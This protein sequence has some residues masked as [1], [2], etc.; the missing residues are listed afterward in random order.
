E[1][2]GRLARAD[3]LD[4]ALDTVDDVERLLPHP[5]LDQHV[6]GVELPLD[7]HL[8][9][10]LDLDHF[11]HRDQR[12]PDQLASF[13]PRIVGDPLGDQVPDLVLMPSRGLD[14]VPAIFHTGYRA[15]RATPSTR[16]FC[17]TRS[18][19]PIITPST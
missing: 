16:I 15:N 7:V 2:L 10:V 11:L 14:G 18:S 4:H 6:A 17:R 3:E 1:G 5:H 12:L 8:L 19:K 9:A 13:R